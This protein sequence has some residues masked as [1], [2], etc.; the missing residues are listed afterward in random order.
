MNSKARR[1]FQRKLSRTVWKVLGDRHVGDLRDADVQKVVDAMR[2]MF[3]SFSPPIVHV[4]DFHISG[5]TVTADLLLSLPTF[6]TLE[7]GSAPSMS[8]SLP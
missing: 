7:W 3:R 1:R 2:P 8:G 6:P 4:G 5:S